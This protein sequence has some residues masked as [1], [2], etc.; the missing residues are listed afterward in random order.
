MT[1]SRADAVTS[2]VTRSPALTAGGA[3]PATAR[4]CIAGTGSYLPDRVMTNAEFEKLVETSDE[5]I[6]TRTGIRE[7]RVAAPEQATSDLAV[8]AAR[9]AMANA[10]VEAGQ[11]DA[12]IVATITPDSGFPATA[13]LV[14]KALGIPTTAAAFDVNAACTGFLYGL[15]CARGLLAT[16]SYRNVLLIGAETLS[17]ITDYTDRGTCILFGDGAGAA[18]LTPPKNGLE[19][20]HEVIS[21]F[22][23]ADGAHGHL[24][25]MPAGGS[26]K[27]TSHATV[28]AREHF[29]RMEGREVFK[30]AVYGM[31]EAAHGALA[32]A[33]V[34]AG[35]MALVIPHQANLRIIDAVAERLE[36]G[37][38]RV[39]VNVDRYGNCSAA[40]TIVALDEARRQG[41]LKPGDYALL[42]AFGAGMTWGGAV[43]RW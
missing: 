15:E 8:E 22:L 12:V 4:A 18:V 33:G 14:Q 41:R 6:R 20:G 11:V 37:R 26:R 5:W 23:G 9:L 3:S 30:L 31:V 43:L 32:R 29:L 19:G 42:L 36:V 21:V 10:G 25:T 27:P 38:D 7:R 17:R 1:P 40:T 39:F 35:D 2:A 28:D 13:C 16:G 34:T 24:L